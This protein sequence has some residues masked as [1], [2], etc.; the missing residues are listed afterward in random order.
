L[1]IVQKIVDE[2]GKYVSRNFIVALVANKTD[3]K[4]QIDTQEG[5]D[6]A[7]HIKI[8]LFFELSVKQDSN[9]VVY[10]IYRTITEARLYSHR[11]GYDYE[12]ISR[13]FCKSMWNDTEARFKDSVI[14]KQRCTQ[15]TDCLVRVYA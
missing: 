12:K 6:A 10:E 8:P 1:S 9:D 14:A 4:R 2:A 5:I 15:F 11:N 3:L 13:M 7:K